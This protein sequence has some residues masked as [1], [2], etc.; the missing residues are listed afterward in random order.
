MGS[1][2]SIDLRLGHS[3][4]S[5]GRYWPVRAVQMSISNTNHHAPV[6]R[7]TLARF[8]LDSKGAPECQVAEAT[9]YG[10]WRSLQRT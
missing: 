6:S 9:K 1:S 10:L 8:A 5:D 3:L 7:N 2:D 4:Y